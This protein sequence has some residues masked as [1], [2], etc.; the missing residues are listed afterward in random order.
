MTVAGQG[1]VP[2]GKLLGKQ[3]PQPSKWRALLEWR[4]WSL[5]VKLAAVSIVPILIALVLGIT[6][7]AGQVER[8]DSHER[9]D[10]LVGVEE[11]GRS[12]LDAL[13]RERALT[14]QLLTRGTA[15]SS[16][17]LEAVRAEVDTAVQEL[18]GATTRALQIDDTIAAANGDV[19]TQLGELAGLRE[20]VAA[21]QVEPVAAVT[22]YSAVTDALLGL[23]TAVV[24]GVNDPEIGKAPS[25]LHALLAAGEE[26]SVQRA[27]LDYG[28]AR[29]ALAPSELDR[30]R[31]TEI[32]F[33]DRLAE[34]RAAATEQ[35]R[36]DF[37][38]MVPAAALDTRARLVS[39]AFGDQGADVARLSPQEWSDTSGAVAA[40]LGELTAQTGGELSGVSAE[41]VDDSSSAAG[42]LSV[43]LF[44]ALAL[45]VAVVFVITTHLLR[46]LRK[47]RAGAMDVAENQLPAA[48]VNIQEGRVQ[49]TDVQPVPVQ[50]GGEI[51]EVARAFDAVHTQ[52]L[53][54]AVEQAAMRTGYSSVFVNLSRRSQSLVQRQLQLIERLERDEEDA[55]QLA[56]L[57]Q[58]DHLATRMRRNNENLMVLSGAE[59][60]RRSG[61]PVTAT[62]VMRAAVSEIE[63]YQRVI[64]RTPPQ[65]RVVGF[66]ASDLMRLIAE[67]LDNATAFSAPETQVTVVTRLAEDGSLSV[68]ILDNGIGMNEAEVA[69]ANARLSESGS[70]DLATSRRMG[71]FVVGRLATRQG[72]GVALHG[73]KDI[74][75]VRATVTVPATLVLESA[76]QGIAPPQPAPSPQSAPAGPDRPAPVRP[77]A[78][79]QLPRRRPANG[80]P[81]P[82]AL[83]N[84]QGKPSPGPGSAIERR[85]AGADSKR[86]AAGPPTD[87]EVS[88]TALFSPISRDDEETGQ[89]QRVPPPRPAEPATAEQQAPDAA[90]S[91]AGTESGKVKVPGQE[92]RNATDTTDTTIATDAAIAATEPDAAA[93]SAETDSSSATEPQGRS[94]PET[95]A[96]RADEALPS[97]KELFEANSRVLSDWW[98]AA[99]TAADAERRAKQAA[100]P[101]RS[102]TTPIFDAMLSA[103][104]RTP[105]ENASAAAAAAKTAVS[106]RPAD[107]A[108]S[109]VEDKNGTKGKD[110]A[111]APADAASDDAGTAG[112]SADTPA[113]ASNWDFASDENWRTVQ[114]VSQ[115]EPSSYTQAGLPRRTRGEQLMPGSAGPIPVPERTDT[116][117]EPELPARDPDDVRGRLSSFQQGVHRGRR[118]RTDATRQESPGQQ[119]PSGQS[120]R[121]NR[122][123]TGSGQSAPLPQR[124]PRPGNTPEPAGSAPAAA[125]AAPAGP[126]TTPV[127]PESTKDSQA[128]GV[129]EVSAEATSETS[130]E[131]SENP[132]TAT[133]SGAASTE[134]PGQSGTL[135]AWSFAADD[136]VRAAQSV[137]G[138]A[139]SSFTAAGL[140]RRRRGEQLLPGSAA[141]GAGAP[142]PRPERDPQN[143]RGRLSSFQQG[144]RR[145]RHHTAQKTDVK[146]EKVEGE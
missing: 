115:S 12:A 121:Q 37:E 119:G 15:G 136:K 116:P 81:R 1:Q 23:D 32:R 59:P 57:F 126:A 67:L 106:S 62:D 97:G 21:G 124:K 111:S 125:S 114:A 4:D 109:K 105:E 49:G 22:A 140:P 52:A 44:A 8:A 92:P 131:S 40:G 90:E 82:G 108:K 53:R 73:G 47:L 83:S 51:G 39:T 48:V 68:D 103:W 79:G 78:P 13:Q 120:A 65:V 145:G 34:F 135:S 41:L 122:S 100:R 72:F 144:I 91:D 139:P 36:Q 146:H 46:S 19:T 88:G 71:L 60:G 99:T 142:A 29:D 85:L 141:A 55:D 25:A 3:P 80:S 45:A 112:K 101:G 20:Q 56:T 86:D 102:E 6:T 43:L 38:T 143:V 137:P 76:G 54:L 96:R 33:A 133:D 127:A 64:V 134:S 35:R 130:A 98:S 94:D 93:P 14:A 107:Q 7:I 31:A 18:A 66:A 27:L 75:G 61:Q 84:L 17:E 5:P 11:Q 132:V 42:V 9:I 69:E 128:G 74:V 10:A 2:V 50:A 95:A 117:V 70:I 77:P 129:E 63:Q 123:A 138:S 28:I 104:F 26:L 118:Q 16:D 89:P 87:M 110:A 30:L 58:L 113:K 24:S